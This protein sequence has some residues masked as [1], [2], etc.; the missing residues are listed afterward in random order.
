LTLGQIVPTNAAS[1]VGGPKHVVKKGKTPILSAEESHALL[2]AITPKVLRLR[3][4]SL[5]ERP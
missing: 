3:D 2:D 1:V 5:S 4:R